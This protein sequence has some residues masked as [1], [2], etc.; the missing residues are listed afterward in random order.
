MGICF[1]LIMQDDFDNLNHLKLK[2][3][4]NEFNEIYKFNP[5]RLYFNN[6]DFALYD[7]DKVC[8]T[9]NNFILIIKK[10]CDSASYLGDI[11]TGYRTE[12]IF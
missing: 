10:Y 4:E 7:I 3:F 2:K 12:Q 6:K 1:K 8:P 11:E 5:E 9:T